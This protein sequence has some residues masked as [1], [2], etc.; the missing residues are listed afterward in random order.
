MISKCPALVVQ[1]VST[2]DVRQTI[3]FARANGLLLSIK[4][5]GHNIA[6]TALADG[7]LTLDMS[8]MKRV[9]VDA[10]RRV[11]HVGPG[12][13]LGDVDRNTQEHGLAT[14]LGFVS[15]TGVAGLTLGGGFGYLTRR[16]G[17]TVDNLEEV[18]IVTADGE[19]RRAA[20]DH[21]DL[22]WALRGG[23]GNFGVVTRFSFRL[24]R[25]RAG[26]HRRHHPLGR[27][28]CRGRTRLVPGGHRD[29]TQGADTR[30][31]DAAR[32]SRSLYSRGLA[33]QAS[34]CHA[35]LPHRRPL[36]G[37]QDL[38]PIRA[39]GKPVTDVIAQKRYVDQQSMTDP[40]S[41]PGDA[42]LLEV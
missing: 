13:L 20:D 18:E 40:T 39:L 17:W 12:C 42:Q 19:V 9:E 22:F 27:R 15:E 35:R 29:G 6:G 32:T 7:G 3:G 11:V 21:E 37:G 5:G 24:P 38:A 25:G 2:D 14:V 1:P 4:G 33:W 10:E 26:D 41:A 31:Y 36:P 23:G 8:R 30:R 28:K 16:F 34:H